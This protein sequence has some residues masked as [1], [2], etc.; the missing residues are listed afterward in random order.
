VLKVALSFRKSP[1]SWGN[2]AIEMNETRRCSLGAFSH[3]IILNHQTAKKLF[4]A[5]L[6]YN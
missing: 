4:S 1:A 6:N 3:G 5:V 2:L